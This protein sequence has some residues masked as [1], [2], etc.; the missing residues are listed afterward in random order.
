MEYICDIGSNHNV[1]FS[2]TINLI[3]A[4]KLVGSTAVKCQLFNNEI[5]LP[6]REWLPLSMLPILQDEAHRCG[7]KFGC[8]PFY[9]KAVEELE[10][11][12]DF[13]KLSSN[14]DMVHKLFDACAETDKP[15]ICS[16]PAY[17]FKPSDAKYFSRS[18]HVLAAIPLYPTPV[19]EVHLNRIPFNA[20]VDG[21]SDHTRNAGVIYRAVHHYGARVIEFHMDLQDAR[22]WEFHCGHC[23]LPT[24]ISEVI[25]N[26]NAGMQ[27]D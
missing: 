21:W 5:G 9:L 14:Y 22:G 20:I 27:V 15:I 17:D 6:E 2:R 19:S 18:Q 25:K 3:H 23:W 4:A 11:Y 12:V 10:S 16:F 7:L 13:Y 8:S 24:E 1:D 26:I